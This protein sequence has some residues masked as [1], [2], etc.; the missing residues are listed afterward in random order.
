VGAVGD[1]RLT[2]SYSE[3]LSKNGVGLF[4]EQPMSLKQL[5]IDPFLFFLRGSFLLSVDGLARS[6]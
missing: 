3:A 4:F 1:S 2:S 5:K 6:G